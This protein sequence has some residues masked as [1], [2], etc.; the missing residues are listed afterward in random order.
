MVFKFG[1]T[2]SNPLLDKKPTKP[3]KS[4]SQI[5]CEAK[6]GTWDEET[7]T[8]KLPEREA[9]VTPK[10]EPV[11]GLSL[12]DRQELAD[13]RAREA[14]IEP[15]L[16]EVGGAFSER[17]PGEI[18]LRQQETE[19]QRIEE[20]QRILQETQAP[21][22]R[23]LDPQRTELEK[24]FVAGPLL[25]KISDLLDPD[26][27]EGSTAEAF[28]RLTP[29][30][31]E[32][33]SPQD[34]KTIAL[35]EIERNEIE[36]GLTQSEQFGSFVESLS[37]GGLSN[38]A[39][40]KPSENVQTILRRVKTAKT[41]ATNAEIKVKDGTWRQSYGE[42]VIDGIENDLQSMESRMKMLIQNSPELKFDSDGVNFI[43]DKIFEA[44]ERLFSARINMVSGATQ[45]PSEIQVLIAL[46]DS[47]SQEEFE[48]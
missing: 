26:I 15:R 35:S 21:V 7:K 30:Q 44:R 45:D 25:Q 46:Q 38:F 37:L 11:K 31:R 2:Q 17:V 48:L 14:G 40:E 28:R 32:A 33:M 8:C 41:R 43:E 1:L 18:A 36:A 42:E 9:P 34:L 22:R 23:E 19:A 24:V 12:K 16:L 3:E 20:Q 27:T 4:R 39:A 6:G 47:I 13:A 29:E 5:N 10:A